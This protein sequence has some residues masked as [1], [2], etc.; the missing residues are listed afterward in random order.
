MA[1]AAGS[2]AEPRGAVFGPD[3]A[4]WVEVYAA[5]T[6][7]PADASFADVMGS[8]LGQVVAAAVTQGDALWSSLT[9]PSVV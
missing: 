1:A 4:A 2:P 7:I 5:A 9:R 3:P 8:W 6:G